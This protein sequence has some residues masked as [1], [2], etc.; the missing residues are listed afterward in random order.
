MGQCI[1]FRVDISVSTLRRS[2]GFRID[3]FDMYTT[4]L[5]IPTYFTD[6]VVIAFEIWR[7]NQR[8]LQDIT[9]C[10]DVL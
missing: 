7:E 4:R 10:N 2:V 6:N 9:K 5:Y 3:Y 1:G 8:K